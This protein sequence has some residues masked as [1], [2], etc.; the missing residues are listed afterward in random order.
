MKTDFLISPA[1]AVPPMITRRRAKLMTMHV[2]ERVPCLEG[3][4]LK[5]GAAMIVNAWPVLHS[6]PRS[7]LRANRLCH[8][9]S[10]TTRTGSRKRGSAPAARSWTNRSRPRRY[11]ITSASS[12]AN[13]D[14]SIGRFTD[15][16][17]R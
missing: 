8:A 14:S 7:R 13:C 3:D 12:A 4:A 1:Y 16:H 5:P 11:A 17:H 2:S 15:P 10:V 6:S 9:R